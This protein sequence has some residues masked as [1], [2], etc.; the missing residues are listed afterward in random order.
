MFGLIIFLSGHIHKTK[1]HKFSV[2]WI[3]AMTSVTITQLP[4]DQKSFLMEQ[5]L[6]PGLK[7]IANRI[8]NTLISNSVN[9]EFG[10]ITAYDRP[11]GSSQYI[12]K[13]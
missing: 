7:R 8:P 1:S 4:V 11:L 9:T 3:P 10:L 5:F 2:L 6:P 13:F 12:S